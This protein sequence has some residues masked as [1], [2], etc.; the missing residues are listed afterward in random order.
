MTIW[1]AWFAALSANANHP[2]PASAAATPPPHCLAPRA[3]FG[4][5]GR[6]ALAAARQGLGNYSVS[7]PFGVEAY[8]VRDK[9]ATA[10]GDRPT[11]A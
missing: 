1:N 11:R 5:E 4:A 10:D 8:Q 3:I 7:R 2:A 6:F 9:R